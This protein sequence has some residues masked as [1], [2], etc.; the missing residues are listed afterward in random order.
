MTK[1]LSPLELNV[2]GLTGDLRNQIWAECVMAATYLSN[3]IATRSNMKSPFE[4]FY[5]TKPI[6]HEELK[7]FGEVGVVTTKDKI[8]AKLANHGTPCI[9]VGYAE[10]HSKDVYRMLNL[11]TKT[12][13]NSSDIIWLKKMYK[14]CLKNKLMTTID[15]EEDAIELPTGNKSNIVPKVV[16]ENKKDTHE[17]VIRAMKKLEGWFNPQATKVMEDY[18]P[19]RETLLE[20]V[21]LA[22]FTTNL[23]KEPSSYEEAIN[24]EQ[25][26]EQN[27]WK[28]AI[29]R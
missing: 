16:E 8:H 6:L 21:N 7:I 10:N 26:E 1:V 20:Q 5:N 13:I 15:E 2:T 17:R 23:V 14:D 19:G 25:K 24:C 29:D 18:N 27:A 4:L 28:E 12:I 9:F 3:V 11:E 22:L